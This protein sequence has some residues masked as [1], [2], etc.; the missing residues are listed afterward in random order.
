MS[1]ERGRPRTL[2]SGASELLPP[3]KGWLSLVLRSTVV[4][5]SSTLLRRYRRGVH[6]SCVRVVTA[7]DSLAWWLSSTRVQT[8]STK[9]EGELLGRQPVSTGGP[10]LISIGVPLGSGRRPRHFEQGDHHVEALV[11]AL[12]RGLRSDVA[13]ERGSTGNRKHLVVPFSERSTVPVVQQGDILPAFGDTLRPSMTHCP[14]AR[15]D[16]PLGPLRLPIFA[17]ENEGSSGARSFANL[18]WPPPRQNRITGD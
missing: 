5:R 13:V 12:A 14:T 1:E 9:A 3:R 18:P 10:S 2:A 8:G 15:P 17:L 6:E 16:A 4:G 11:A 7:C